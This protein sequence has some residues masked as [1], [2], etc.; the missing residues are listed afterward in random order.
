MFSQ[1][2]HDYIVKCALPAGVQ[3][4]RW[5]QLRF[6]RKVSNEDKNGDKYG[7]QTVQKWG[8]MVH[9][10]YKKG[11]YKVQKRKKIGISWTEK[12]AKCKRGAV[13]LVSDQWSYE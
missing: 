10:G 5:S 3:S 12:G 8:K 7:A 13:R 2:F 1:H 6:G 9:E 11:A 4:V